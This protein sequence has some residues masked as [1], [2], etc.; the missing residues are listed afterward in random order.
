MLNVQSN[1]MNSNPKML[2]PKFMLQL[3]MTK[4]R[5][6]TQDQR[7]F[8]LPRGTWTAMA[9]LLSA[10]DVLNWIWAFKTAKEL[11]MKN[12]V[13]DSM[14]NS[15]KLMMKSGV[16]LQPT[17]KEGYPEEETW[18]GLNASART[19]V[20]LTLASMPQKIFLRPRRNFEQ[21]PQSQKLRM[22]MKMMRNPRT[23]DQ[24]KPCSC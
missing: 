21:L 15:A 13:P 16:K 19:R 3:V 17:C 10:P 20:T 23:A 8:G 12:A 7:G 1:H 14:P 22:I 5:P 6:R 18:R 9:Q 4:E 11:T 2:I 24:K